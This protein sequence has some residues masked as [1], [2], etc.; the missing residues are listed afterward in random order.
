MKQFNYVLKHNNIYQIKIAV[1]IF[2]NDLNDSSCR[3]PHSSDIGDMVC[4]TFG[5]GSN[6]NARPFSYSC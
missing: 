3:L 2:Y 1:V 5:L 4:L 6:L